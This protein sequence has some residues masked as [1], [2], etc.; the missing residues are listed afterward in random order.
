MNILHCGPTFPNGQT[1]STIVKMTKVDIKIVVLVVITVY[2]SWQPI[3]NILEIFY[4]FNVKKV[5]HNFS[6]MLTFH[7]LIE[8]NLPKT[9]KSINPGPY[10]TEIS[11]TFYFYTCNIYQA[12]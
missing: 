5:Q 2:G 7:P 10:L 6:E 9:A 3:E 11:V 12:H 1:F 8:P 4:W